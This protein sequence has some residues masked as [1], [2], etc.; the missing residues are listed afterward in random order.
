[1]LEYKTLEFEDNAQQ[2]TGMESQLNILAK[3]GWRVKSKETIQRG[4]DPGKT[5]CLGCLFFPLALLGKKSNYIT[6]ILER[7]TRATE[8]ITGTRNKKELTPTND[9]KNPQV[10]SANTST[11]LSLNLKVKSVLSTN[12]TFIKNALICILIF[13][14]LSTVFKPAITTI[15]AINLLLI[16]LVGII[17]IITLLPIKGYLQDKKKLIRKTLLW[18]TVIFIFVIIV[19]AS[20]ENSSIQNNQER[21]SSI[22][23]VKLLTQQQKDALAKKQA[24]EKVIANKKLED[25][26]LSHEENLKNVDD[27]LLEYDN[28]LAV[29]CEFIAYNATVQNYGW[30][31][32]WSTTWD[33]SYYTLIGAQNNELDYLSSNISSVSANFSTW[34]SLADVDGKIDGDTID[35]ENQCDGLYFDA[36]DLNFNNVSAYEST[37]LA[38]KKEINNF[39]AQRKNILSALGY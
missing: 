16:F 37:I 30:I 15:F 9:A 5:C 35:I 29:K 21:T 2:R 20:T 26:A 27:Q 3:D 31:A 18:L 8:A 34:K 1:M 25:V 24:N 11:D 22:V 32:D 28:K 33:D 4:W 17:T 14:I 13:I 36:K 39:M 19:G 38:D 23:P 6:V 12:R 7:E 10:M